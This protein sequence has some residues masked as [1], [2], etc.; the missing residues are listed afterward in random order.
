MV[1]KDQSLIDIIQNTRV[2][3]IKVTWKQTKLTFERVFG[4]ENLFLVFLPSF[5]KL[6]DNPFEFKNADE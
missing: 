2:K 3:D 4:T 5:R 6:Q 1:I